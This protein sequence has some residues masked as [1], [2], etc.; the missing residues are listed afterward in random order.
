MR[1]PLRLPRS[2]LYGLTARA[3]A[4]EGERDRNF[5][6]DTSD[7]R[8]LVLKF[9]DHEADDVVVDGQSAALA[10]I[11]EQNTSLP[12][13]RV[14]PTLGGELIGVVQMAGGGGGGDD[15]AVS[16]RARL[17]T[18]LPGRLMQ[19]VN[20]AGGLLRSV[21]NHIA[22]LES[23]ARGVLPPCPCA[24]D[25][26]GRTSRTRAAANAGTSPATGPEARP[27][28]RARPDPTTAAA[29]ARL[30]ITSH[31]RRLSWTKPAR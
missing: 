21:G 7:G 16:C 10:H 6:L 26:M 4:L 8:R 27:Q 5:R 30:A 11:A 13:P 22:Q 1:R 9:I 18:Y 14:V 3:T 2:T 31:S 23:C 29:N 25:C 24:A 19:D 17:V 15:T 20:P 28:H 12:V